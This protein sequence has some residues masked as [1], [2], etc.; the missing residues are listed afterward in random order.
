MHVS[1]HVSNPFFFMSC[2]ISFM[3]CR[4]IALRSQHTT[5]FHHYFLCISPMYAH[6]QLSST[7]HAAQGR[8]AYS[9]AGTQ[10]PVLNLVPPPAVPPPTAVRSTHF[11]R[12][13]RFLALRLLASVMSTARQPR[14][15]SP[16]RAIKY[17]FRSIDGH[18]SPRSSSSVLVSSAEPLI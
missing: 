5:L 3:P 13:K 16:T 8:T 10:I 12:E 18:I 2:R 1:M 11:F 17:H 14:P 4:P 9:H 15:T 6:T 7:H